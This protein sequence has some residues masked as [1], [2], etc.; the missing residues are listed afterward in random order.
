MFQFKSI[1]L[2]FLS[3]FK[4]ININIKKI[5][6]NTIYYDN[7]ISKETASRINYFPSVHL[8]NALLINNNEIYKI[9]KLSFNQIWNDNKVTSEEYNNLHNFLWLTKIDRKEDAH[10]LQN[11]LISWI[12]NFN[13]YQHKAWHFS[14]IGNRLIAWLSNANIL[15]K[16]CDENFKKKF[17]ESIL[18]QLNHIF[19]NIKNLPFSNNRLICCSSIIL[20]GLSFK[21]KYNNLKFGIKELNKFILNYYDK[22]GFPNTR[23][24]EDVLISLKYLILIRE[25]LKEAKEV[26]PEN[27]NEIIYNCGSCFDFFSNSQ[28]KLPLFNGSTDIFFGDYQMFLKNMN[29]KFESKSNEKSGYLKINKKKN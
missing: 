10:L 19:I 7:R 27:L 12:N 20:S 15:L 28:K 4:L 24:P 6:Y 3:L 1:Q 9:P 13:K 16:N 25:W 21:E 5:Y 14:V 22:D 11:L 17:F 23:N 29:Y 18:K 2:Y 8:L 26:V